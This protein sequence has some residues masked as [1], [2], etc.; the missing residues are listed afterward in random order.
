VRETVRTA[1]A[2]GR[3]EY[4]VIFQSP[5]AEAAALIIALELPHAGNIALPD[6]E[7]PGAA[8]T[9]RFLIMQ[10]FSSGEIVPDMNASSSVEVLSRDTMQELHFTVQGFTNPLSWRLKPGWKLAAAHRALAATSGPQAVVLY[11]EL[12]TM[13]RAEGPEWLRAVYHLQNRALQFLPLRLPDGM[14]LVSAT[15]AGSPVRADAGMLPDGKSGLL[16]PL[17]QTRPGDL[18]MDVEIVCR[19]KSGEGKTGRKL[20]DPD[21]P[22][23]SIQRTL[24]NVWTPPGY[25]LSDADGNMERVEE[26]KNFMEKLE[27]DFDELTT[28]SRMQLSSKDSR[29]RRNAQMMSESMIE[30]LEQKLKAKELDSSGDYESFSRVKGGDRELGEARE[31]LESLKK[32]QAENAQVQFSDMDGDSRAEFATADKWTWDYNSSYLTRRSKD[33]GVAKKR[34][35]GLLYTNP[36]VNAGVVSGNSAIVSKMQ[37]AGNTVPGAKPAPAPTTRRYTSQISSLNE[38][39]AQPA[40]QAQQA[41]GGLGGKALDGAGVMSGKDDSKEVA[42]QLF[43]DVRGVQRRR[44]A[45]PTEEGKPEAPATPPGTTPVSGLPPGPADVPLTASDDSPPPAEPAV[46]APAP[47]PMLKPAGRVSIPVSFPVDGTV[48]RFRKVN[49]RAELSLTMKPVSRSTSSRWLAGGLL[50]A[51]LGILWLVNRKQRAAAVRSAGSSQQSD[52]R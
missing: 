45:M 28:L 7:F 24:W 33:S 39:P 14:E 1:L 40:Q 43:N 2:D 17:I 52:R 5:V 23:V 8:L 36:V 51:G 13:L 46:R 20:E 32:A 18:A 30:S 16:I 19:V 42:Q 48:H 15:V 41:A 49:D 11:A 31:K 22:G 38:V 37:P 9:E 50:A 29:V 21:I 6:I 10:N 4:R 26:K 35:Q 44:A 12:T 3:A 47:P 27:A 34:Q 25:D